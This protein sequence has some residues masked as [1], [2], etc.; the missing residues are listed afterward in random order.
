ML[1]GSTPPVTGVAFYWG[2]IDGSVPT[3][4]DLNS[5]QKS[6]GLDKATLLSSGLEKTVVSHYVPAL[7]LGQTPVV[8][9]SGSLKI[10]DWK[11]KATGWSYKGNYTETTIDGMNVYYFN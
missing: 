11:N 3:S 7:D 8:A 10:S 6:I 2:G 9:V 4:A 1:A 5:L